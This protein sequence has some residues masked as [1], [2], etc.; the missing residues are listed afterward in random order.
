MDRPEFLGFLGV[1]GDH[2]LQRGGVPAQ[3]PVQERPVVLRSSSGSTARRW[4]DVT[5]HAELEAGA[6]AQARGVPVTCTVSPAAGT[7]R[8][9]IGAQQDQQVGFVV[10]S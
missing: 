5:V 2:F 8:R 6:P 3:H 1:G 10:A 9:G 4:H 7:C